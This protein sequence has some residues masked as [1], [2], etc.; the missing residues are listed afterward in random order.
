MA[1]NCAL[2]KKIDKIIG[3]KLTTIIINY[4]ISRKEL[5]RDIGVSIQQLCKYELG[6]NR[7]S[8]SRLFLIAKALKMKPTYFYEGITEYL[9]Q[10]SQ[11]VASVNQAANTELHINVTSSASTARR[12][13]S[14]KFSI[15][16]NTETEKSN[17][18]NVGYKEELLELECA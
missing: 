16:R 3:E 13:K 1:R 6:A 17:E 2:T 9:E 12:R 18:L 8:S 5:A 7:I 4:N 15:R 10:E 14:R 11:G